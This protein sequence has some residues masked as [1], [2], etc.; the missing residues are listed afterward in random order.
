MNHY[1]LWD[2][3]TLVEK[4]SRRMYN[5][6]VRALAKFPSDGPPYE[7][8]NEFIAYHLGR[9]L[10]L[11][12]VWGLKSKRGSEECY[13][14]FNFN[15]TIPESLPSRANP[16]KLVAASPQRATGVV[17]FDSWILNEDRH[18]KN[19][20]YYEDADALML[21]DHGES[22]LRGP[23]P[24]GRLGR[25]EA[26]PAFGSSCIVPELTTLSHLWQWWL[27]LSEIP[28]TSI[29]GVLQDA[30]G[31]GLPREHVETLHEFL[32][33]RRNVVAG[34]IV[35]NKSHFLKL[36]PAQQTIADVAMRSAQEEFEFY[37]LATEG[38]IS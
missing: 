18:S 13:C 36:K 31:Y 4:S 29:K 11:P 7:I 17:V 26:D 5:V 37:R 15:V 35:Q 6:G 9:L 2:E 27:R 38:W 16:K 23:D 12:V 25:Y 22:L 28:A 32:I 30:V 33:A 34:L 10:G 19:L 8:A 14:S 3:G 21:F 20:A 24:I 1:T